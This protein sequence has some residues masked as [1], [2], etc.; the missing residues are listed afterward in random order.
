[1]ASE[2]CEREI[3]AHAADVGSFTFLRTEDIDPSFFYV[4]RDEAVKLF[5]KESRDGILPTPERIMDKFPTLDVTEAPPDRNVPD[6]LEDLRDGHYENV[7]LNYFKEM[8]E[9]YKECQ[10]GEKRLRGDEN[11]GESAT[12]LLRHYEREL[13]RIDNP[14]TI[15][16]IA[17]NVDD[18]FN[19]FLKRQESQV[20]DSWL[21]TFAHPG[22]DEYLGS[23]QPS[24]L[25]VYVS[26]PNVGK[27][28]NALSDAQ[29]VWEKGCPV[30][31]VSLEMPAVDVGFRF[32]THTS[33]EGDEPGWS[34]YN[35]RKGYAIKRTGNPVEKTQYVD[36]NDA[37]VFKEYLKN[38]QNLR[39]TG[40][41]PPFWVLTQ[42]M[43]GGNTITPSYIHAIARERNVG[44]VFV[45]YMGLVEADNP[46]DNQ[47]EI[48]KLAAVSKAFKDSAEA[49]GIPYCV[50]HQMNRLTETTSNVNLANFAGSD[51]VGRNCTVGIFVEREDDSPVTRLSLL[52]ARNGP[53]SARFAWNWDF[54][55]GLRRPMGFGTGNELP[56]NEG[57]SITNQLLPSP[58]NLGGPPADVDHL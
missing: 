2:V 47:S 27:T 4:Y 48:S 58:R 12:A 20:S 52:K 8:R 37:F 25:V 55:S 56:D 13:Q 36:M 33:Q 40:Q 18:R 41:R 21:T 39:D 23:Y 38:L 51:A 31:W 17:Y 50:P 26:R 15:I 54:D 32:D 5:S 28:F 9:F 53:K 34:N 16:D 44:M 3:L 6:L 45:D 19:Y 30:L 7:L 35:L 49:L 14:N 29:H 24:D 22:M 42:R 57:G 10:G 46:Y 1:M 43:A 11:G